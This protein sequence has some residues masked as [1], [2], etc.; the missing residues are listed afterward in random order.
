[1]IRIPISQVAQREVNAMNKAFLYA[2]NFE[3]D[4]ISKSGITPLDHMQ[5]KWHHMYSYDYKVNPTLAFMRFWAECD[6]ENQNKL[7]A[8]INNR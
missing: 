6:F 2:F 8:Y 4:F 7:M 3:S 1:M 5:N